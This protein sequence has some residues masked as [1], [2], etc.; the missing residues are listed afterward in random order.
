[1]ARSNRFVC[2][3]PSSCATLLRAIVVTMQ[4]DLSVNDI[5]D[6]VQQVVQSLVPE[7][8]LKWLAL[9]SN[10]AKASVMGEARDYA[11]RNL[12]AMNISV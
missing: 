6:G 2:T 9:Q 1:M 3:Q 8:S 5:G 10:G 4:L 12:T 7:C 11:E